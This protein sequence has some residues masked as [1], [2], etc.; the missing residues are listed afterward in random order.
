M[1]GKYHRWVIPF[2][3]LTFIIGAGFFNSC[4]EDLSQDLEPLSEWK[5]KMIHDGDQNVGIGDALYFYLGVPINE[6]SAKLST[7]QVFTANPSIVPGAVEFFS[8]E[9]T[10]WN[11]YGVVFRPMCNLFPDTDYQA[12]I[13]GLR[14]S[15]GSEIPDKVI[16]FRTGGVPSDLG[17]PLYCDEMALAWDLEDTAGINSGV[18]D[19]LFNKD[20]VASGLRLVPPPPTYQ[21][22]SDADNTFGYHSC[23]PASYTKSTNFLKSPP[24]GL[25]IYIRNQNSV[26]A[27]D[28]GSVPLAER[29]VNLRSYL[30][31][32]VIDHL[33]G[34]YTWTSDDPVNTTVGV[35]SG[36]NRLDR[37]A[38]LKIGLNGA[39]SVN[40]QVS[41]TW[42]GG[43]Y[44]PV[45]LYS[46]MQF[47]VKMGNVASGASININLI[48]YDPEGD[49]A[50]IA[51][52]L[53][54]TDIDW[55]FVTTRLADF[56]VSG[57]FDVSRVSMIAFEV[58]AND[59]VGDLFLDFMSAGALDDLK[60]YLPSDVIPQRTGLNPT[61]ALPLYVGG[62]GSTYYARDDGQ[63]WVD[64][65]NDNCSES[66]P[67]M[68]PQEAMTSDHLARP[69]P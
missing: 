37:R 51:K 13:I 41:R 60:A 43:Q 3:I 49:Y 5:D 35:D 2:L 6:N 57:A 42:T 19:F 29:F 4:R 44:A 9:G 28:L 59:I 66:C 31:G 32:E 10:G 55:R 50:Y 1:R 39:N 14:D 56:T 38:C 47:A 20:V 11:P 30:V 54:D 16:N 12:F 68:S 53:T 69:A 17:D 58:A 46:G 26:S 15:S 63:H 7:V 27:F 61:P 67:L 62:D 24:Y 23:C 36:Q 40:D 25:L 34:D 33:D 21:T 52:S 8:Y 65:S 22:M 64:L 45:D 18:A 48:L